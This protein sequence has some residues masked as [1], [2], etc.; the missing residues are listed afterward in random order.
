MWWPSWCPPAT[1][2]TPPAG[3]TPSTSPCRVGGAEAR[4][5]AVGFPT[6]R[7]SSSRDHVHFEWDAMDAWFEEDEQ[8]FAHV[9]SPYSG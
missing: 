2:A 1:A 7:S 6:R 3:A 9:R 8:V 4:D 5:A